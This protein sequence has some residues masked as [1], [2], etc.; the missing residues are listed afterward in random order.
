MI[1]AD[2]VRAIL[3]VKMTTYVAIDRVSSLLSFTV[4]L[5]GLSVSVRIFRPLIHARLH[6]D[7]YFIAM[8]P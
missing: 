3:T 1:S 8:K 4:M 2:H 7:K 5:P 6:K